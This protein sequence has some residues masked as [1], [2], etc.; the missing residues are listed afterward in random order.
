MLFRTVSVPNG[1]GRDRADPVRP[2]LEQLV[3]AADDLSLLYVR[4]GRLTTEPSTPG[5]DPTGRGMGGKKISASPAPWNASAANWVLEV[6]Q[7]VREH[8]TNLDWLLFSGVLRQDSNA[9]TITHAVIRRMPDLIDACWARFGSQRFALD[10]ERDL[11]A[12]GR[13]GRHILDETRPSEEPWAK[14]PAGLACP[15]CTK[16]LK[17]K[18]GWQ[19][20]PEPLMWCMNPQHDPMSWSANERL[21][22]LQDEP[23]P[24]DAA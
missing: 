1:E 8:K 7:G 12:W 20:E 15:Y 11:N 23:M 16:P 10:A 3:D 17:L 18:P 4:I 5:V 2:P 19:H 14:A 13:R 21:A 22:S 24:E 6:H 9:D